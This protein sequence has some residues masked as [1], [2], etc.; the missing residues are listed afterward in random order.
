[1]L[2]AGGGCF[3]WVPH[4]GG[5]RRSVENGI[6][7][8]HVHPIG[9]HP[10][11]MRYWQGYCRFLPSDTFLTECKD[12]SLNDYTPLPANAAGE[13]EKPFSVPL[14]PFTAARKGGGTFIQSLIPA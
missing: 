3:V 5:M 4:P 11:R 6:S 2:I 12:P 9:M 1:M 7:V 10:Y 14:L 8:Q 13:W